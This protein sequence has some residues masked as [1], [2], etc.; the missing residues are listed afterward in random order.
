M[1]KIP[2]AQGRHE[3]RLLAISPGKFLAPSAVCFGPSF[4]FLGMQ[5][6]I[7]TLYQCLSGCV[8]LPSVFFSTQPA[9]R[10]GGR[11]EVPYVS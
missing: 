2:L 3:F 10:P 4:E 1:F 7:C 5:L 11:S 8:A 6:P 9:H